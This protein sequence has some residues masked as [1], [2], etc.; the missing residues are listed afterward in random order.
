MVVRRGDDRDTR[1][2]DVVRGGTDE[3]AILSRGAPG[4]TLQGGVQRS[5]CSMRRMEPS[6]SICD[7]SAASRAASRPAERVGHVAVGRHRAR[8]SG[9]LLG[10][11]QQPLHDG[12]M[13]S[14][15]RRSGSCRGAQAGQSSGGPAARASRPNAR[16]A[17]HVVLAG[18]QRS[19]RECSRRRRHR[20]RWPPP[21]THS[22]HRESS[23]WAFT[24]TEERARRENFA[25]D[26]MLSATS[27]GFG[28]TVGTIRWA[29]TSAHQRP[30]SASIASRRSS[31]DA[32]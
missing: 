9:Q 32:R 15:S 6:T 27:S 3:F 19:V 28:S 16:A 11:P 10:Q 2:G 25:T 8:R 20:C 4:K 13:G 26:V 21:R 1:G 29:R 31:V 24:S 23:R 7:T 22:R 17:G 12:R 18:V 14:S 30:A 5:R